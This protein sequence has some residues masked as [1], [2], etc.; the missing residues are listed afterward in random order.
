MAK[1]FKDIPAP[2]QAAIL[3]VA[4]VAIAAGVFYYGIP[5]VMDSVWGLTVKRDQL[6]GQ[7]KTLKAQNDKN[8]VF[9][10]QQTEYLNRIK[11]LETQLETLRS[12]VPDDQ[13]TDEFVR[14]VYSTGTSTGV[15]VRSFI[16]KDMVPKDFYYEMPF[17]MRL[18]G[19]YYAL[20][21][22]FDRLAHLQRIASVSGLALGPP[23]GGG[24]GQYTILPG[25]TVG[26]NCVITTYFNRP[27]AAGPP[28]AP[29][30]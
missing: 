15:F 23:M 4:A 6:T 22:F 5:G 8:E 13:A 29:K 18:D 1:S 7:V 19:T 21:S 24:L 27:Q 11:Q 3:I 10:Q 9:R 25:E 16:A 14:S 2:A 26:A 20:V 17:S 30:K 12:I 28:P